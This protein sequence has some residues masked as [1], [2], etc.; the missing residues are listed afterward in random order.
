MLN[1]FKL[2][3]KP[4]ELH[5][6]TPLQQVKTISTKLREDTYTVTAQ[7][8]IIIKDDGEETGG[9][10][11]AT[12]QVTIQYKVEVANAHKFYRQFGGDIIPSSTM[13]ARLREALQSNSVNQDI[14]SILKGGLNIVRSETEIEL[15][16]VK[17]SHKP[18]ASKMVS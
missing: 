2:N 13:E 16:E 17:T 3:I 1:D 11:W 15:H 10:Q 4:I 5:F 14:F 12:Y 18:V 6:K 8:G 7:T 9:G